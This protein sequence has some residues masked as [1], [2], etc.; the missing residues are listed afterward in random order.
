MSLRHKPLR[1]A[2]VATACAVAGAALY[3]AGAA[4]AGQSTANSTHEPYNIGLLVKD[5]DTYYG[6]T[7]DANGVYQASAD[8]PYAK[9]LARRS[10][11]PRGSTSTRRPARRCT[12]ARSPP[13]SSTSTTR[14][15][16]ASTTRSATT[17]R[18]TRTTWA[19]YVEQGRPP[20]RLRQ[21]RTGAVRRE[22]GRRGLLQLGPER[23]AALRR[24]REP[25]ED[26]RR[27]EPRR[28][29]HVPQGQGQPA[30]L[31]E[32]LR[33]PRHLDLHDRAVQVRYPQAHREGPRVRDRRQLRRPVLGPRRRLR[34]PT[35][36]L[37]NPTYFVS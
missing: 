12:R 7:A 10:T 33:H 23:G 3:G 9:D 22:E 18:T 31:P 27:G 5:I 37:P 1:V 15:C 32:R 26:R 13:S 35:Y 25:E 8:S 4:T 36:K 24:R 16:S 14:C 30:V 19:A 6:T 17:T 2:A 29:P 11:R 34:R 28:R 20:G 21:R